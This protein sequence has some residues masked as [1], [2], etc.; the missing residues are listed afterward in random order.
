MATI[1]QGLDELADKRQALWNQ[2]NSLNERSRAERRDFTADEQH[3]WDRLMADIAACDERDAEVRS[4]VAHEKAAAEAR[5]P[6]ASVIYGHSGS[7]QYGSTP[8]AGS[9]LLPSLREYRLAEQRALNE[10]TD[11]GGGYL[12]PVE[13]S[14]QWFDRLRPASVVLQAAPV[15]L[16]AQAEQL[17]VPKITG[18][19]TVAMVAEN[20]AI[21]ESEE[22]FGQL[23]LTPRKLAALVPISNEVLADSQP[24]IRDLVAQDLAA[25][26][27]TK[28]DEQM[29]TGDGTAPNLRGIRNFAGVT[30]TY[31]GANGAT[32]TLNDIAD[33]VARLETSNADLSR[34][35]LFIHPRTWA[36]FRKIADSQ[37]RYQLQP[38]PT[39]AEQRRLFG[40]PVHTSSQLS[41]TETRG[42]NSDCSTVLAVDMSRVVVAR[43]AQLEIAYS[44]DYAFHKDQTYVRVV[45]RFDI[46]L[47]HAAAVEIVAGVRP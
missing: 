38:D 46:G 6:L 30:T 22:T 37:A 24:A 42:T 45:A 14:L 25:Q 5:A 17:A 23:L 12:V 16:D 13:Q 1:Q 8:P 43:R 36:T 29:L 47:V 2:A 34:T 18:S 35:A 28:L 10:G 7:G 27:G 11:S 20:A 3:T 40:V 32:P 33:A 15:V 21:T 31:L 4:I 41:I 26:L 44:P 19:A 39:S 9:G